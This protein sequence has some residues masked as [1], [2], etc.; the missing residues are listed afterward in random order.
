LFAASGFPFTASSFL[1]RPAPIIVEQ[2]REK[3]DYLN[4]VARRKEKGNYT[5]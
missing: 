2:Y 5:T 4:V 1:L 3:S